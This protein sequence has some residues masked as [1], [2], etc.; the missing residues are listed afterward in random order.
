MATLFDH[1]CGRP[2]CKNLTREPYCE[3]HARDVEGGRGS[4]HARGYDRRWAKVRRNVLERDGW[5]CFCD[6]T[7]CSGWATE[8][9]HV[10]PIQQGGRVLDADNCVSC[11][12]GCHMRAEAAA[13]G[14]RVLPSI[15]ARLE[16]LG[17]GRGEA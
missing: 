5:R 6:G 4:S 8:V 12:H 13:R 16:A 10:L 9:H 2:G 3:E 17:I 11:S 14:G 7:E 15:A 1:P